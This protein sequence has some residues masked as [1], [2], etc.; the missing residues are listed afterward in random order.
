MSQIL[1]LFCCLCF[2]TSAEPHHKHMSPSNTCRHASVGE[3]LDHINLVCL[4][5]LVQS[6]HQ[7]SVHAVETKQAPPASQYHAVK[8]S[9]APNSD[10]LEWLAT[11]TDHAHLRIDCP[12]FRL[13]PTLVVAHAMHF[14][15]VLE[16]LRPSQALKAL[17]DRGVAQL[18]AHMEG[19]S[20]TFLHLRIENDWL[21][22][23]QRWS[24]IAVS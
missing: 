21:G 24:N 20:F 7:S 3:E 1:H 11:F 8:M 2:L 10:V 6:L 16:A 15:A 4:Q 23:C 14:W 5:Y 17:V 19:E 18:H 12:L 9:D 13:P 22:H